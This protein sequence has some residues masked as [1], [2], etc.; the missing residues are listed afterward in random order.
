[1][2]TRV[3]FS[4][5]KNLSEAAEKRASAERRSL[6]SYIAR[7]IE[8]DVQQHAQADEVGLLLAKVSVAV[9]ER[10]SVARQI[11]KLVQGARA[12]RRRAA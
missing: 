8:R 5:E 12:E 6:S 4:V 11:N 1:M 9:R 2:T 10:P 3:T 7:L